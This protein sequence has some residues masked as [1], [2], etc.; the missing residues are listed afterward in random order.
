MDFMN[1]GFN[2]SSR[3]SGNITKHQVSVVV[4]LI[5]P[6]GGFGL[7]KSLLKEPDFSKDSFKDLARN[8][9]GRT[10]LWNINRICRAHITTVWP[11][12][13]KAGRKSRSP[14]DGIPKTNAVFN[15]CCSNCTFVFSPPTEVL[16]PTEL[17]ELLGMHRRK[18]KES[19]LNLMDT[20]GFK[21][22]L[23]MQASSWFGLLT[24]AFHR[25]DPNISKCLGSKTLFGTP[26]FSIL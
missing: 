5:S 11:P 1:Q 17:S 15:I 13:R 20:T 16:Q 3:G 26:E 9:Q 14:Q 7:G 21:W 24:T 10:K 19:R 4:M 18:S 22:C 6:V 2:R 25:W 12:R 23:G 8:S